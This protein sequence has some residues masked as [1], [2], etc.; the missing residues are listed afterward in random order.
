MGD[1]L[2]INQIFFYIKLVNLINFN[3]KLMRIIRLFKV[4]RFAYQMIRL[5]VTIM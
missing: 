2:A 1:N 5:I 3:E 4:L